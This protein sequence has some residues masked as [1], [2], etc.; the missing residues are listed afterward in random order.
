M[1]D[2]KKQYRT[3]DGREVRIYATDGRGPRAIHGA[4]W[5][6][7][8]W[9]QHQW[10]NNG[11]WDL[12]KDDCSDLIQVKPRIKKPVYLHIF[13]NGNIIARDCEDV[14]STATHGKVVA[15]LKV[16]IDCEEGEGL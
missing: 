9:N 12:Y 1:I 14:L 13:E 16:E 4:V 7:E 6:D 3:R 5:Y 15:R 8:Q 2:I 10:R 11:K